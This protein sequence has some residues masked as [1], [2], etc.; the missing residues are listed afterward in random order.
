MRRLGL[1]RQIKQE[2]QA[3]SWKRQ[4]LLQGTTSQLQQSFAY[5]EMLRQKLATLDP[6]AVLKRGYAVVRQEN[7]II[8]RCAAD[9]TE[10][11]RLLVEL[12]DGEIQV[13]VT[14]IKNTRALRDKDCNDHE[15]G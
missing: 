9:L 2:L 7:G 1:E 10:G 5:V 3:L 8:A 4:R 14:E 13:R 15:I 11:D 12:N 6:K